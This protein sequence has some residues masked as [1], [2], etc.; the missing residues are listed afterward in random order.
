MNVKELYYDL[1]LDNHIKKIQGYEILIETNVGD[2]SFYK[3]LL[4]LEIDDDNK[5]VIMNCIPERFPK[6][7]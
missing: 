7:D 1:F 4:F 5:R 2:V 6:G 3:T